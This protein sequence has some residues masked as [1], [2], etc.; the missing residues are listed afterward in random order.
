MRQLV[1]LAPIAR[2]ARDNQIG[3]VVRATPI[4]RYYVINVVHISDVTQTVVAPSLLTF[5]LLFYFVFGVASLCC[6]EPSASPLPPSSIVYLASLCVVVV[7]VVR[8]VSIGMLLLIPLVFGAKFLWVAQ[9]STSFA[10][11]MIFG[12]F[13]YPLLGIF[14]S[15]TTALI[16]YFSPATVIPGE[17]F[18][19][20]RIHIAAFCAALIGDRLIN[21]SVS[22]SLRPVCHAIR[23]VGLT[24]FSGINLDRSLIIPQGAL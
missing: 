7:F 3:Q 13:L 15:A 21:H 17:E 6:I 16:G 11:S 9:A 18:Q 12:M 8:P 22:L 5:V 14:T 23:A 19:S 4:Q 1:V 20:G 24:A 2:W 10:L